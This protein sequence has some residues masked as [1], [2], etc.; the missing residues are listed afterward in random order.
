MVDAEDILLVE[1]L[2]DD[3][4][5]LL[6]GLE[7]VAKRL[8]DDDAAPF[9]A[10]SLVQAGIRQVLG[11]D[12]EVR[13]GNRQVERVVAAGA[14][15][16]VELGD[17]VGQLAVGVRIVEGAR[18]E[19]QARAQLVPGSFVEAGAC[20][21]LDGCAHVFL[22]VLRAPVATRKAG[23]REGR[24]EEA[25]VSEVVDGGKELLARKVARDAEDD[26]AAGR[27]DARKPAI[28]GITQGG[29][30]VGHEWSLRSL[31][32]RTR[33]GPERFARRGKWNGTEDPHMCM[34]IGLLARPRAPA[35][36]CQFS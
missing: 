29:N 24:V 1:D 25:A 4:G 8:L 2:R 22:E 16:T 23:Q 28:L 6:C 10:L 11:H 15:G 18:D 12:G 9:A 26:E 32:G 21:C 3:V 36:L 35:A 5:E 20:V 13:R 27:G 30:L 17:G 33:P 34:R 31:G 14:A 7:V 19:A